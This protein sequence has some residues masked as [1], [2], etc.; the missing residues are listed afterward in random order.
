MRCLNSSD[1]GQVLVNFLVR[2]AVLRI[3]ES[4]SS[5]S[6]K[7]RH[8]RQQLGVARGCRERSKIFAVDF[9]SSVHTNFQSSIFFTS[10]ANARV[11]KIIM[12]ILKLISLSFYLTTSFSQQLNPDLTPFQRRYVSYVKRCDELGVAS[13]LCDEID[14]FERHG[15]RWKR[16]SLC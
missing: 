2:I 16:R 12:A 14:K 6:A 4:R 13:I 10:N 5:S 11:Q 1:S 8:R 7:D 9:L 15:L 3:N